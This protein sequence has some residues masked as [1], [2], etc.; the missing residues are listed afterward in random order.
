[1]TI[2]FYSQF[3][4][5]LTNNFGIGIGTSVALKKVKKYILENCLCAL[6]NYQVLL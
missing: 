3:G 6:L 4:H 1:M 2:D 5:K